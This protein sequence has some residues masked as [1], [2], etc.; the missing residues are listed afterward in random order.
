MN[1]WEIGTRA[2]RIEKERIPSGV[3]NFSNFLVR[4]AWNVAESSSRRISDIAFLHNF[5]FPPRANRSEQQFAKDNDRNR[6]INFSPEIFN[7]RNY[8]N[9]IR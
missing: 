5:S 2:F 4:T 9:I 1:I 7:E 6:S 3:G 8:C